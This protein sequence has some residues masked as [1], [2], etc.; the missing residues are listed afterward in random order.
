MS[1]FG[2]KADM[3]QLSE[4]VRLCLDVGKA[5]VAVVDRL[6][7]L[8]FFEILTDVALDFLQDH[9][10]AR[11]LMCVGGRDD[12]D[13]IIVGVDNLARIDRNRLPALTWK[14]RGHADFAEGPEPLVAHRTN[15]RGKDWQAKVVAFVDVAN[16]A[17]RDHTHT[18]A[19]APTQSNI[20]A[21]DRADGVAICG[22]H[23]DAALHDMPVCFEYWTRAAG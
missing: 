12:D 7:V 2:G 8:A 23:C 9:R 19:T 10:V 5:V 16:A 20:A 17:V 18:A 14:R 21:D 6:P 22:N 15:K 11:D 3:G 1:A 13:A 4:N